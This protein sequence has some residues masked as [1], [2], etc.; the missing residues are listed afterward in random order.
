MKYSE[1]TKEEKSN[2]KIINRVVSESFISNSFFNGCI[3]ACSKDQ[4]KI[5]EKMF[6]EIASREFEN[7]YVKVNKFAYLNGF[8][9]PFKFKD[10]E[11]YANEKIGKIFNALKKDENIEYYVG[12]A[13]EF[14]SLI[15]ESYQEYL[16]NVD[17]DIELNALLLNNYYSECETSDKLKILFSSL[18]SGMYLEY[19]G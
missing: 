15:V 7:G 17:M 10:Y 6:T 12:K 16:S 2:Q 3:S 13:I 18:K 8:D 9:I 14:Q 1:M 19:C 5:I 4:C 11:K